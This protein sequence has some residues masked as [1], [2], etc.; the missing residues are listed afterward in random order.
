MAFI[1]S[2]MTKV[3]DVLFLPFGWSTFWGITFWSVVMG[4]VFLKLYGMVTNQPAIKDVKRRMSAAVLE[5]R[6]FQHDIGVLLKA[7]GKLFGAVFG[8]TWQAGRSIVVL[9]PAAFLVISQ[10]VIRFDQRALEPNSGTELMVQLSG[11]S[12]GSAHDIRVTSDG[13][14]V[15]VLGDRFPGDEDLQ[16]IWKIKARRGG[17]HNLV[18]TAGEETHQIPVYVG[19]KNEPDKLYHRMTQ[20]NFWDD[21]LYPSGPRFAPSSHFEVVEIKY[22]TVDSMAG[23]V[24]RWAGMPAALWY[25]CI[26]SLIA[27]F[28]LKDK[29][30]VEL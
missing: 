1:A 7:Q 15:E 21:F 19:A 8:Y 24:G 10:F 12:P 5:V 16:Y 13:S 30:G 2:I 26:V 17:I 27:G 23:F 18:V 11:D 20:N 14:G 6:L 3:F 22:D 28:A 25:F 4:I 29:L 9:L